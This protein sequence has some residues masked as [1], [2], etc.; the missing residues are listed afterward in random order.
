MDA[1]EAAEA[2]ANPTPYYADG[3]PAEVIEQATS[4]ASAAEAVA[5]EQPAADASGELAARPAETSDDAAP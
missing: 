1:A 4:E 5:T 3:K 2:A